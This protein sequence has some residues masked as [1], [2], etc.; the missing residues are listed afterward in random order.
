MNAVHRPT[1]MQENTHAHKTNEAKY[2][3]TLL[4]FKLPAHRDFWVA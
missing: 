3:M 4:V 2:I 1:Y